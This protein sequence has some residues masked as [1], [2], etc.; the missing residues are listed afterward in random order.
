METGNAWKV[1]VI[2]RLNPQLFT[3]KIE[4]SADFYNLL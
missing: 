2:K 3:K 4:L 1:V